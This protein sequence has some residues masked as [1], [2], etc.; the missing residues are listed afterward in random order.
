LHAGANA[1]AP[2]YISREV[3][4]KRRLKGQAAGLSS[5]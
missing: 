2:Q 4:E 1:G 3:L 5:E